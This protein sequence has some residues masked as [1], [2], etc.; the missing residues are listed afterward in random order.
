MSSEIK[1]YYNDLANEY[2]EDRFNNS[3]GKFI[4]SQE[5]RILS[6]LIPKDPELRI[7]DLACGTGRLTSFATDGSDLSENMIRFAEKLYPEKFFRVE[8]AVNSGWKNETFDIVYSFHMFMHLDQQKTVEIFNSVKRI[9]KPG[10]HFIFDFPSTK[11]RSLSLRNQKGWHGN[12][13]MTTKDALN[14]LGS[15]WTRL[16]SQG[17]L[18]FPIHRFPKGIRPAFLKLDNTLCNSFAKEYASYTVLEVQKRI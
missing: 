15:D 4:H 12:N 18:F 8:D 1:K 10:G 16:S 14:L 5:S 2:D 3:Y 9:L 11:R 7:L 6:R 13:T 17:I